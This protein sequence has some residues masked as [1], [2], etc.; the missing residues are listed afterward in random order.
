MS[1]RKSITVERDW[2]LAAGDWAE[3]LEAATGGR[4]QVS[5]TRSTQRGVW[6]VEVRLAHQEDTGVWVVDQ[7]SKTLWPN[8]ARNDLGAHVLNEIIELDKRAATE[9]KIP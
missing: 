5:L 6:T 8:A 7:R 9:V 3:R 1:Q 2:W 4:V